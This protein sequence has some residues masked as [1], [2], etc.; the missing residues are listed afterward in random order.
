MSL[1]VVSHHLL[2]RRVIFMRLR[3][4][5][6]VLPCLALSA[7]LTTPSLARAQV[8]VGGLLRINVGPPTEGSFRSTGSEAYLGANGLVPGYGYPPY[9]GRDWPTLREALATRH[10]LCAPPAPPA[11]STPPFL[12]DAATPT[13]AVLV[14]RV[15][16]DAEVFIDDSATAQKGDLRSFVTPPLPAGQD[17]YYEVRARWHADGRAHEQRRR[18]LVRP[19]ARVPVDFTAAEQPPE[20]LKA[21]RVLAH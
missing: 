14:V 16:A 15:P 8:V 12:M 4:L 18:V 11:P 9:Y 5:P 1:V 20:L 17:L 21:P 7:L 19:G 6:R 10:S 2:T 3:W 13:P